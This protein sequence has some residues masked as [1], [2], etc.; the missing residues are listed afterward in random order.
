MEYIQ[1]FSLGIH[2]NV[3]GQMVASCPGSLITKCTNQTGLQI[4]VYVLYFIGI[5]V[6]VLLVGFF[7]NILG[8]PNTTLKSGFL[9]KSS[10]I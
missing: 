2:R 5:I 7:L 10:L 6:C 9:A 4:M 3:E 1:L 8:A